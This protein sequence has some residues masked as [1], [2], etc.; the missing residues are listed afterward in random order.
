VPPGYPVPGPL[1][2]R[3]RRA[4]PIA[5]IAIV[6]FLLVAVGIAVVIESPHNPPGTG[7]TTATG[8]GV[9]LSGLLQAQADAFNA[10]DE[11]S[12]LATVAPGADDA[13]AALDRV[14]RNLRAIGVTSVQEQSPDA[15]SPIRG[16]TTVRLVLDY[17]QAAA[18]CHEQVSAVL[19]VVVQP[20][21]TSVLVQSFPAPQVDQRTGQPLPWQ[22]TLLTVAS[23]KEV[24]LA[25]GPDEAGQLSQVLP[26]AVAAAANADKYALWGHPAHYLI[27]LA[28]AEDSQFWFGGALD[29]SIGEAI[30]LTDDDIE[31][32]LILPDAAS[33]QGPGLDAVMAHELG[34]VATL[35]DAGDSVDRDS[36]TEGIADYI[37]FSA[38]PGADAGKLDLAATYVRSGSWSGQCQMTAEIESH[39]PLTA[40]A[41]YAIGY[42]CLKRMAMR[43]GVT[44][45][46]DFWG[47]VKREG[48]SPDTAARVRFGESY[49]SVNADCVAYVH[50]VL[51]A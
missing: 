34:H 19:R 40:N 11:T 18:T 22:E 12:Y 13:R 32:M 51:G 42:L 28:S 45:M 46:L 35:Y 4:A 38:H 21:G 15:S 14:Y 3:R 48:L 50:Q 26:V 30:P 6:V 36:F 29:G 17:C 49:A 7:P 47:D 23:G 41:A 25:A 39:D 44:K 8:P 43:F 20:Y 33:D 9:N 10:G 27:Y 24:T 16:R 37:A 2:Y 31:V 5:A 1:P